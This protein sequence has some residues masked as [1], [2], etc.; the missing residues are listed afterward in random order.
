MK[1]DI[2]CKMKVR[3]FFFFWSFFGSPFTML[4]FTVCSEIYKQQQIRLDMQNQTV[5]YFSYEKEPALGME[6]NSKKKM[7]EEK[8][9]ERYVK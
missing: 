5:N 9:L 8:M 3:S 6:K 4:Q 7:N 1:L 2:R